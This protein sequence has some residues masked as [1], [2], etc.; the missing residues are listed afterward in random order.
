MLHIIAVT[1]IVLSLLC[2]ASSLLIPKSPLLY[3]RGI[4]TAVPA[5]QSLLKLKGTNAAISVELEQH[6]IISKNDN[7]TEVAHAPQSSNI[8]VKVKPGELL[9]TNGVAYLATSIS[10]AIVSYTLCFMLVSHGIDVSAV[11]KRIGIRPTPAASNAGTAAI[12]YAMHKAA[13][14]I[15]FPPTVLL[16]PVTARLMFGKKLTNTTIT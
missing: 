3:K 2:G 7:F 11:L 1:Y 6:N 9:A 10:F 4:H 5:H 15:R 13:S 14:P 12:A 8:A 16:T